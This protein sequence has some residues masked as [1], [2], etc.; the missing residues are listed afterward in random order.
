LENLVENKVKSPGRFLVLLDGECVFC[1]GLGQ[2][3]RGRKKRP[4]FTVADRRCWPAECPWPAEISRDFV[5]YCSGR[6]HWHKGE[7]AVLSMAW[8]LGGI[9]RFLSVVFRL[10]PAP[11]RRIIYRFW[12]KNRYRFFGK[13]PMCEVP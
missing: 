7:A 6:G 1:S 11:I 2:W 12:S 4:Q 8:D 3:L 10:I 13:K 5:V 9:W